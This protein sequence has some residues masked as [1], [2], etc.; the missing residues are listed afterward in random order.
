MIPDLVPDL[1]AAINIRIDLE[2]GET[3]VVGP[4]AYTFRGPREFTGLT[5]RRDPGATVFWV[6]IGL[7]LA[8]L[9]VTFFLPRRRFWVRVTPTRTYLAGLAGHGVNLRREFAGLARRLNAPDAPPPDDWED[10]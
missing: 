8:G 7:G 6:A 1:V 4:Y 10:A 2:E 5:V 3:R 9:L